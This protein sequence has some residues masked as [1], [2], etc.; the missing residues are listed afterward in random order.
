MKSLGKRE[1]DGWRH[2]S[3]P[4]WLEGRKQRGDREE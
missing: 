3:V 4:R 1:S 2:K